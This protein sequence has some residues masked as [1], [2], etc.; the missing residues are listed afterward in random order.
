VGFIKLF[1]LLL[2]YIVLRLLYGKKFPE[3]KYHGLN[4]EVAFT[5][6]K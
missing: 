1:I 6:G 2:E 4:F 3:V 5:A